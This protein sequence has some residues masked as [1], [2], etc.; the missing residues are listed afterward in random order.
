LHAASC[1]SDC[2]G[3][4]TCQTIE[5]IAKWDNGNEYKLWDRDM[6]MGCYCDPGYTGADCSLRQCKHGIDPLYTNLYTTANMP[7]WRISFDVD[8]QSDVNG[9]YAIKFYDTYGEDYVTEPITHLPT[10]Y[11][12]DIK[13][14]LEALPNSVVP[15]DSVKVS[16]LQSAVRD[17][18][19]IT[20]TKNPGALKQIEVLTN[21][22]GMVPTLFNNADS[23]VGSIEPVDVDIYS[24]GSPGEFTD[25]FTTFCEG[26]T[27]YVVNNELVNGDQIYY[28]AKLVVTSAYEARLLKQ[29]LGDADGNTLNNVCV[30]NWDLGAHQLNTGLLSGGDIVGR[31]PHALKLVKQNRAD[32]Y[33]SGHTYLAWFKNDTAIT[34]ISIN[35]ADGAKN[36]V[37]ELLLLSRQPITHTKGQDEPYYVF[38]TDGIVEKISYDGNGDKEYTDIED[39]PVVAW[40]EA[41]TNVIYTNFD[42]SC[43]EGGSTRARI[44]NCIK[45]GDILFLPAGYFAS[46]RDDTTAWSYPAN[47]GYAL[48]RGYTTVTDYTGMMYTVTK[49]WTEPVATTTKDAED[50]YRIQVDKNI[51]WN[52]DKMG[53]PWGKAFGN[54][55]D[56][57]RTGIQ[58]IFKFTPNSGYTYVAEC[59]NRGVCDRTTGVCNCFKGYTNDNCDTQSA[60]AI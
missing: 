3:H 56:L 48:A 19:T 14:A 45:K 35:T 36:S 6:T 55:G 21:L 23:K 2:S 46:D 17:E 31:Y 39:G 18:Y 26:V 4:G 33:D 50:R 5:T 60:L 58:Q 8:S 22:D 20:F 51:N 57:L 40:W 53:A 42:A 32:I 7:S 38:G 10:D 37:A 34:P 15:L 54:T 52:G 27:A 47:E 41:Y 16:I 29:C 11:S 28:A 24:S 30:E 25:H 13:K 59:A 44:S 43:E 12:A 9:T 49:V 1:P